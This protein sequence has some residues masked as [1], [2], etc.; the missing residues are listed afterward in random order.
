MPSA[1]FGLARTHYLVM[2]AGLKITKLKIKN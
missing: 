1:G 2:C